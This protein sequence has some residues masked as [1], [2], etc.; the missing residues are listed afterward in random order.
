MNTPICLQC[1]QY[2]GSGVSGF[3]Y[4]PHT[5]EACPN[6]IPRE[7]ILGDPRENPPNAACQFIPN[8]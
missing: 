7:T 1:K 6:G 2:Q 4:L 3:E 5:C 8:S